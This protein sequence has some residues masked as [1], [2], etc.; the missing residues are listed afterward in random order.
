MNTR[1]EVNLNEQYEDIQDTIWKL[2]T[3][4]KEENMKLRT[5]NDILQKLVNGWIKKFE[6][7]MESHIILSPRLNKDDIKE[8]KVIT[9][10]VPPQL[11]PQPQPQPQSQQQPQQPQQQ[12]KT[13]EQIK[14]EK[15]REA[16]RKCREK[17]RL[18]KQ[19][20]KH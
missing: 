20:Q 19:I 18:A 10:K 1:N 16:V 6:E 7:L 9:V 11:Q 2:T 3:S 17:K 5:E 12:E 13:A 8:N 15:Q 4:L 14:K